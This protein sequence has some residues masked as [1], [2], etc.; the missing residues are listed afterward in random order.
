MAKTIMR[1]TKFSKSFEPKD[2]QQMLLS[3]SSV[4]AD[5]DNSWN[6]FQIPSQNWPAVPTLTGDS[7]I[8]NH[9]SGAI[10]HHAPDELIV[11]FRA[12]PSSEARAAGIAQAIAAVDGTLKEVLI[13]SLPSEADSQPL[14]ARISVGQGMPLDRAAKVLAAM[15]NVE[16][17]DFNWTI[18]RQAFSSDPYYLDGSQWGVYGD[19]PMAGSVDNPY[20]SQADEAWVRGYTGSTKIVVGLLDTGIDYRNPDLHLNVWLN[21]G[22]IA[23]LS[24]RS[25]LQDIDS[26]QLITFADLN[27]TQNRDNPA[28]SLI[29]RDLNANGFIDAG[30]LLANN[31]G[32]EDGL[33]NE[34]DGYVDDLIGWDFINNDNDPLDDEAHGTHSAGIISASGN[35]GLMVAGVSWHTQ[36]VAIKTLSS[37]GSGPSTAAVAGLNYYTNLANIFSPEQRFIATNNSWGGITSYLPS[38]QDAIVRSAQAGALFIAAAGNGGSDGIGDNLD[39]AAEY[40]ASFSTMQSL[41]YEAVISVG[42]LDATGQLPYYS[43]YG[44]ASVDLAAPGT[45]IISTVGASGT[46]L[47]T[48]TSEAA[49]FVTG[50]LA[51]Y[52][53]VR[54]DA[55]LQELRSALLSSVM[56]TDSLQGKT[57]TGGRLDVGSLMDILAYPIDRVAPTVAITLSDDALSGLE[58]AIVTFE[59]SEPVKGFDLSD[60]SL[61]SAAGSLSNLSGDQ[62]DRIFTALFIPFTSTNDSSNIISIRKESYSDYG[63][64]LGQQAFSSNFTVASG[65][66]GSALYGTTG[67]DSLFGS[68]AGDRLSGIPATSTSAFGKGTVDKLTGNGGADLFVLG[69]SSVNFY[70]DG[71]ARS[72]GN[73]DYASIM[74][75]TPS[76]G[77]RI[78]VKSGTM[79]FSPVTVGRASGTGLY[80]DSNLN[81]SYDSRDEL[82]GFLPGVDSTKMS[83]ENLLFA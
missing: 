61:G 63:G 73:K 16:G 36:L 56:Q 41:G 42:A 48:G 58:T 77:D 5:S 12:N 70:N 29:L 79:F 27:D 40:P 72:S 80:E 53:A 82:L 26:D 9:L 24:F 47:L 28:L 37:T 67:S 66:L 8:E 44:A 54:P 11:T 78:Q 33:D 71:N 39:V 69:N 81:G 22:E 46:T 13:T 23:N 4:G 65:L 35:N 15:A 31:S 32:W 55:T 76:D 49:P 18:V 1:S 38:L 75:F 3:S 45:R 57:V 30:D 17:V 62:T 51:L 2:E 43:N 19:D 52:A 21:Q 59:F 34:A 50:A 20:G 64:N 14:V 6:V 83:I 74:D 68:A 7:T 60:L 10:Q 25:L